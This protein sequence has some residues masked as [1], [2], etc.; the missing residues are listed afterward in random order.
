MV[1]LSVA[2]FVALLEVLV[3]LLV[4]VGVL[5]WL[6]RR[7]RQQLAEAPQH[8]L[9]REIRLARQRLAERDCLQQRLRLALLEFE[10][11]L[12][13]APAAVRDA[14]FW[15]GLE[16]RLAELVE[17]AGLTAAEVAPRAGDEAEDEPPTAGLVQQQARAIERLRGLVRELLQRLGEET[18]SQGEDIDARLHELENSNRELHQCV[19]VLED[20][21]E[22]LRRQIAALL[23]MGQEDRAQTG[24]EA[25]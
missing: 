4:L 15:E 3:V 1:T 25:G 23:Q 2:T 14:A 8:Y 11:T 21:N 18:L 22:F 7:S 5:A 10:Q 24:T 20:E 16:S 12:A 13:G 9:R 19:Q 6:L 17:A